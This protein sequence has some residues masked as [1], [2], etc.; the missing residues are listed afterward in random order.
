MDPRIDLERLRLPPTVNHATVS[1]RRK[2][3]R[4]KPGEKFLRGPIPLAWLQTAAPLPG[5]A[6]HV[7]VALWFWAGMTRNRTVSLNLTRLE[8]VFGVQ[9]HSASRGLAALEKAKLITVVRARGRCPIV[10]L[11]D[12]S[13]SNP[14]DAQ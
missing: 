2:L 10:T 8:G 5:K 7:G 4:H 6:L 12:G 13:G 1:P 14:E 3:P 9:R 11:L